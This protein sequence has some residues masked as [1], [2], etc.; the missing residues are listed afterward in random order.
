MTPSI[1]PLGLDSYPNCT[2]RTRPIGRI[3]PAMTLTCIAIRRLVVL[4]PVVPSI[5]TIDFGG[6]EFD[7]G[8]AMGVSSAEVKRV[9]A[10]ST[11]ER[12]VD[13]LHRSN[14]WRRSS[15]YAASASR[16]VNPSMNCWRTAR[17]RLVRPLVVRIEPPVSSQEHAARAQ[18]HV[19]HVPDIAGGDHRL[20]LLQCA[21][22]R[23]RGLPARQCGA[24][25]ARTNKVPTIVRELLIPSFVLFS[26]L[27]SAEPVHEPAPRESG[28]G[29]GP[30]TVDGESSSSGGEGALVSLHPT[31]PSVS[32]RRRDRMS[33]FRFSMATSTTS[34]YSSRRQDLDDPAVNPH[35]QTAVESWACEG[36]RY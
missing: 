18:E 7:E 19:R 14:E 35:Q 1:I 10:D 32:A 30:R 17:V 36:S 33:P 9:P 25:I 34:V 5:S 26:V 2:A 24:N 28:R 31:I 8:I 15:E 12:D 20:R 11:H 13:H 6:I 22:R 29:L 3:P 21:A 27:L 23:C 16:G 4:D